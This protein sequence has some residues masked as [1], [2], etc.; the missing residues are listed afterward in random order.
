ML[1]CTQDCYAVNYRNEGKELNPGVRTCSS[2]AFFVTKIATAT[3][4]RR[5]GVATTAE[6]YISSPIECSDD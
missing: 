1:E 4:Q 2:C 6:G 5:N 3:F